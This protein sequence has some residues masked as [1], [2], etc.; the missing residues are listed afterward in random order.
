MTST[1][2][3]PF[4]QYAGVFL[5]TLATLMFEILLTRIISVNMW[6]H[7]AFMA[8]SVAMFGMTVGALLVY[9]FPSHFTRE[10]A[11]RQL[12]LSALLFGISVDVCFL[13]YLCVPFIDD[14]Q[15]LG[16]LLYVASLLLTYTLVAI[17]FVLSGICVCLALTRFPNSISRL[18]AADLAGAA[19]G[20]VA[21]VF[22]LR[23][24]EAPGRRR[25][26]RL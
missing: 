9:L 12:G 23:H 26:T 17:P 3:T 25:R 6:Y 4:S 1:T 24:T 2:R 19:A 10:K 18:Y 14:R 7:F 15:T 21:L 11:A 13:A 20:C 16:T 5:V 22:L 8:I